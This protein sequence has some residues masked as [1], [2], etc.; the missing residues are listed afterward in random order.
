MDKAEEQI[1]KIKDEVDEKYEKMTTKFYPDIAYN[2]K[3][4]RKT[5]VLATL[6]IVLMGGMGVTFFMTSQGL[7]I[8]MGAMLLVF[9][10]FAVAMIPGAFKQYPVKNQPIIELN[11]KE[12]TINGTKI[13]LSDIYE[14]RLTYTV[15]TVGTKAENE[16]FLEEIAKKEPERDITANLDFVLKNVPVGKKEKDK[17]LYTTIANGYEA[18]IAFYMSGCKHY[19]IIYSMKKLVKVSTYDLGNTV[20]ADGTKLSNISKKDRLKQLY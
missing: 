18:L 17:T 4:R 15:G 14:I 1:E 2:K 10:V 11:G 20:V 7:S 8:I 19:K 3:E 9:L 16:K 13:K 5:V 12:A 6:L